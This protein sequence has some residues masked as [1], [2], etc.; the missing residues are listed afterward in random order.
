MLL[1]KLTFN[2]LEAKNHKAMTR[3]LKNM[4][5]ILVFTYNLFSAYMSDI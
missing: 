2:D 1:L 3:I 5:K 4:S